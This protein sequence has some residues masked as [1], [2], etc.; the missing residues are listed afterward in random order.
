MV[1]TSLAILREEF[2]GIPFI[3]TNS[4][5]IIALKTWK[6]S[7]YVTI[8]IICIWYLTEVIHILILCSLSLSPS[9]SIVTFLSF[10]LSPFLVLWCPHF[11]AFVSYFLSGENKKVNQWQ[12]LHHKCSFYLVFLQ[13]YSLLQSPIAGRTSIYEIISSS[14]TAW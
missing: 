14:S 11:R 9:L 6:R 4:L 13:Y 7:L 2:A 3:E 10:F 12:K 5:D 1:S 8:I